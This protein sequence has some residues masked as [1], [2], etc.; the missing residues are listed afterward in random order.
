VELYVWARVIVQRHVDTTDRVRAAFDNDA[1]IVGTDM[2]ATLG[3][4]KVAENSTNIATDEPVQFPWWRHFDDH[5][6]FQLEKQSTVLLP[7]HE[8]ENLLRCRGPL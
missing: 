5:P 7:V 4:R 6:P 3:E 2:S 1:G 8:V